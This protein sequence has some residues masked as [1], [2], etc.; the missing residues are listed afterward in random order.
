MLVKDIVL[1]Q[2]F[3]LW[4]VSFLRGGPRNRAICNMLFATIVYSS[5]IWIWILDV[6]GFVKLTSVYLISTFC[7]CATLNCLS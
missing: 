7:C 1:Q 5:K 4:A 6:T 2:N 3:R